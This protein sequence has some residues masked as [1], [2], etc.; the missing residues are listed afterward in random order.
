MGD[1]SKIG[2]TTATWNPVTGC[3]KVS[4][5]CAHCYAESLSLRYKWTEK[6]WTPANATQNVVLYPERLDQPLRWKKPRMIFVNS[7]SDLFHEEVPD[8]YI[9]RVFAVMAEAQHHIFQVLTKRPERM[10]GHVRQIQ[11]YVRRGLWG[12]VTDWPLPNVWLGVSVENQYWADK[13]IPL[14]LETPAAIRF[15]SCEPLLGPIN[16]WQ[17]TEVGP[18]TFLRPTGYAD[19]GQED[20]YIKWVIVGGESGSHMGTKEHPNPRYKHRWMKPEWAQSIVDQCRGAG[21]PV[22]FK[23]GS[24]PRPGMDEDL[25]G[26]RIQEYPI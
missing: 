6:P 26:E 25:L 23:Q 22:F 3:S 1:N 7:M 5:G 18:L 10:L 8:T 16:F 4:P 12:D 11:S 19:I 9:E 20:A 15:L 17:D 24:G 14:L 2:W 13:R 21:V